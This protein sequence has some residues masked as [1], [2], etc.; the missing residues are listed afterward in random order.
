MQRRPMDI[1]IKRESD[2]GLRIPM[3]EQG[4]SE[5]AISL[6][7]EIW[8]AFGHL[9]EVAV[10]EKLLTVPDLVI[11]VGAVVPKKSEE[12][13]VIRWYVPAH[14]SQ[15][16]GVIPRGRIGTFYLPVERE[17]GADVTA[18]QNMIAKARMKR[19]VA[20]FDKKKTR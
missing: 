18:I 7:F 10:L 2:Q 11:S 6:V 15:G 9:G 5:L 3:V 1:E 14:I 13:G 17:K 20:R 12:S 16:R 4:K 19:I 8:E